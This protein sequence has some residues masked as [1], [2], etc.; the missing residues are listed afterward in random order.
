MNYTF[1][2][3]PQGQLRVS[4]AESNMLTRGKFNIGQQCDNIPGIRPYTPVQQTSALSVRA[5]FG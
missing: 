5:L 4:L 3:M 1:L 2:G